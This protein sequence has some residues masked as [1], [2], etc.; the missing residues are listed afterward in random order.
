MTAAND[1]IKWLAYRDP[2]KVGCLGMQLEVNKYNAY[3]RNTF[4]PTQPSGKSK[5]PSPGLI[6]TTCVFGQDTELGTFR[7]QPWRNC[8]HSIP[9]D[10]ELETASYLCGVKVPSVRER[11]IKR[12]TSKEGLQ[13]DDDNNQDLPEEIVE[14]H[15]FN[16]LKCPCESDIIFNS[17]SVTVAFKLILRPC[18]SQSCTKS[19][20][21][22]SWANALLS[23]SQSQ[24]Q[25]V[26]T[27]M[28]V[29]E[30]TLDSDFTCLR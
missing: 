25:V 27:Y 7:N 15:W 17:V 13:L 6:N 1:K 24:F 11:F 8:Q 5:V 12:F 29:E 19:K 9:T 28:A 2:A 14:G 16:S 23:A 26:S 10:S 22:S 4:L 3:S 18:A 30:Y 21:V 20:S